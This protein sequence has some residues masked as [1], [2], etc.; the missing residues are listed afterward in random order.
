MSILSILLSFAFANGTGAA[1]QQH[2][3]MSSDVPV[4]PQTG[5]SLLSE[6][7]PIMA[8]TV[9]DTEG[10]SDYVKAYVTKVLKAQAKKPPQFFLHVSAETYK[11]LAQEIKK[12][13]PDKATAESWLKSLTM[14]PTKNRWNWQ[15]DY[16]ES[17]FDPKSGR[18]VLR[19]VKGYQRAGD[20]FTALSTAAQ[21]K[22]EI[23]QGPQ[24]TTKY[25]KS[26]H[27]GGNIEAINGL[28]LV[29]SDH[30]QGTE[31]D[32]YAKTTCGN[33]ET[34][35][36][37]PSDFLKVGHTD[38]FF[39]T[40][41]DPQ[42]KAPCDFA[43]AFASPQKGLELLKK[44]PEGRLFDFS[45]V[46]EIDIMARFSEGTYA[47]VC[48]KHLKIKYGSPKNSPEEGKN[49]RSRGVTHL[50]LDFSLP[51]A[52]A[53][54]RADKIA[55]PEQERFEQF[56]T[57]MAE[58]E[59]FGMPSD[60]KKQ[61]REKKIEIRNRLRYRLTNFGYIK[62]PEPFS[63]VGECYGMKNKDLVKILESDS[64]LKNFNNSIQKEINAFK[65]EALKKLKQQYPSCS[66]KTV[67][68]PDVFL[69][70][71]DDPESD[72]KYA[73]GSADSIFPNPTNGEM[74]E[75]TLLL[76]EPV[77]PAFKQDIDNSVQALGLKTDY[78]D[79]HFAHVLNG[80]LHCS[81]HTMRY[82]RPQGDAR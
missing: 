42:Q 67:E 79:T 11:E 33:M 60:E 9:S 22:C 7:Y 64:E 57:Q 5:S 45:K 74:V 69:G 24:L 81:S 43:L 39:K 72:T 37:A 68:F 28:C 41:K 35:V 63:D 26:G 65:G 3:P 6:N 17:F 54:T 21:Q 10:G 46:P 62:E 4:C 77:N 1:C 36:K 53:Q 8:A 38:E 32:D 18:P 16:F 34:A 13:A 19:E 59:L 49:R 51:K 25:Y 50:L 48:S 61:S 12:I 27:S 75:N 73:M 76:P 78:I 82:C 14:T 20:S 47:D 66:P 80:N 15:Q 31:W 71:M 56:L 70:M 2:N 58:E 52:M 44:N 29:G 40:L 23:S 55:D 30:F